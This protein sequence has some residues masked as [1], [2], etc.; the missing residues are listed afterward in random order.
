[1]ADLS[2]KST[3][4]RISFQK[5]V[6]DN[7][8]FSEIDFQIE[9]KKTTPIFNKKG[10]A[11]NTILKEGDVIKIID[12]KMHNIFGMKAANI[13]YKNFT[14]YIPINVIR[15]PTGGN[16]TQYEDEVVDA[17]N[18]YIKSAGGV[19][20][21]KLAGDQKIYKNIA[22]AVKVDTALKRKGGAKGDPKADIILCKDKNNPLAAGSIYISHK[23]EGGPEAFQQY[24]GLSIQAGKDIFDNKL[25]QK[26][27]SIIVSDLQNG[28]LDKLPY[29]V[30]GTF[31]DTKL[32]NMSIY[33][34]EYGSAFSLQ[35]T[36]V[37]GQG[38]PVFK[39]EKSFY[40]LDFS[41]HMSLSGD[42]SH[43]TGGYEPVFGATFRAG[44]GFELKNVRYSGARV[45]IYPRK[46][47]EGRGGLKVY[48]I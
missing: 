37:I 34:P 17:I 25:T 15:K 11:I 29:P 23:K 41:S 28:K 47:I 5:Y 19:I 9:N 44:R 35:H 21:I 1:M 18:S 16:G 4:G 12:S 46:L 39:V 3:D 38:K 30:M 20:D 43:F 10:E 26:F 48:K 32:A 24:G 2:S 33:G 13:K 22:Y 45:G 6:T 31:K 7:K 14:G 42:L 40:V 27:L 36:Q 8:R